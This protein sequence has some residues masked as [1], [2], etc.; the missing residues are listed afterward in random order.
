MAQCQGLFFPGVHDWKPDIECKYRDR[1]PVEFG[2]VWPTT[3][4]DRLLGR[5]PAKW[6]TSF[7][8]GTRTIQING[9]LEDLNAAVTTVTEHQTEA[10]L[11]YAGPYMA[12][13]AVR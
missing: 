7:R 11:N 10:S 12:K 2:H 1:H 9:K 13:Q 8:F 5:R 6:E 3:D 4:S